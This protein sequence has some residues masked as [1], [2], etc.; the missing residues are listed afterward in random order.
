MRR[1]K[2]VA[3]LGPATESEEKIV[4][5]LKAGVNL[6]RF[7]MKYSPA[8]WHN[9]RI[10][11]I[12]KNAV[13]LNTRVGIMIDIPSNDFKIEIDDYDWVALSYLKSAKEVLKLKKRLANTKV[14]AKIENGE[15]MKNL[16]DIAS[17]SDGLMVARGDLGR[18]TPIEEL[19]LFQ[20]KIIDMG[21]ISGKPVIVATEMLYSMVKSITPT[22]AEATD[23]ANAVFDGTDALMLSEETAIGDHPIE[24]VEVMSRIAAFCENSGELRLIDLKA[25]SLIDAL[26]ESAAKIVNDKLDQPIKTILVFTQSGASATMMSKYRLNVP[27]TAI[28]KDEKVLNRLCLSYGINPTIQEPVRTDTTL[29][30]RRGALTIYSNS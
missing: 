24:A 9:Q 17:V 14:I 20:K 28:S 29:V 21:R 2:I 13:K 10:A 1:T 16:I 27:V 7:N 3:T 8:N 26:T 15:A 18:E 11:L 12:R 25:K 6:F 19:A 4:G 23:V 30:I 5:L 22:R